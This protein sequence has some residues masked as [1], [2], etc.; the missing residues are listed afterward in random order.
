M[1][2][3]VTG[4]NGFI[5][6]HLVQFLRA[7]GHIVFC[8][9]IGD[10]DITVSGALDGFDKIEH[11]F[12]LAARTSVP[13]SWEDIRGFI[14]VNVMGTV[15]VLEFCRSQGCSL[16]QMS[17]YVYG[18]PKYLPVDEAH[19]IQSASPYHESKI[20]CERLCVFYS[21]HFH[22][23]TTVL[24]PFNVYGK[25]QDKNF[26]IAKILEQ[27]LDPRV[28]KISVMDL[29][30]KR[31]YVYVMDVITA[32]TA[33]MHPKAL[34]SVYNIGSGVSTS[35]EDVILSVF[36]ATGIT[37]PYYSTQ[38]KRRMEI[39]DCVA[40]ITRLKKDFSFVPQYSLVQGLKEWVGEICF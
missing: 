25:G 32:M 38:E 6:S 39:S 15:N 14:N 17:T 36:Q 12:H 34:F 26:L 7:Q 29:E 11:V 10:G 28:E 2:I 13:A 1:R 22:V 24:R 27:V 35:V 16:T 4:A 18:E 5:G 20:F 8:H 9:A 33:T 30:P 21:E 19:P 31:D 3:L 37:K 40:D 23:K